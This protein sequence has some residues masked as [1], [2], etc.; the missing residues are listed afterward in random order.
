MKI[1]QEFFHVTSEPKTDAGTPAEPED[2]TV[3]RIL[4]TDA[5]VNAGNLKAGPIAASVVL[6]VPVTQFTR[7]MRYNC[8]LCKH[9]DNKA[10]VTIFERAD[11]PAAPIQLRTDMNKIRGA[12]LTTENASLE[13][14]HGG[15]DGDMDVEQAIR[16]LGLCHAL[17]AAAEDYV[18]VHP[19]SMCPDE[20][21]TPSQPN[22]LFQPKDVES[23]RIGEKV[24][25]DIMRRA[26]GKVP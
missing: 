18:I 23:E 22:G 15:G 26:Q 14:M 10:F 21:I 19:L 8:M 17:E 2:Q 16:S 5:D 4:T 7:A 12:L 24:Y 13:E 20:V 11:H 1:K 25:D 3:A 9:F 6:K